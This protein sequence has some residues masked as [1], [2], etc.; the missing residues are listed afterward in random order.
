MAGTVT[1]TMSNPFAQGGDNK[2]VADWTATAGGAV[3]VALCSTFAA[4]Q[5]ST[6]KYASPQPSK[7]RGKLVKAETAPGASG[8]LATTLPT[9][10]YDIT[11]L[12]AYS[13]DIASGYLEDRSGTVAEQW[14]P[15]QPVSVDDDI[16]LTIANAGASTK[17]R[18]ILHF[19]GE[20]NG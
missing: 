8:D 6:Y 5:L 16:T 10:A 7:F 18:I 9:A 13:Q 15:I 19:E 20:K 2:V 14:V 4:A 17:G 11:L 3:S 1:L 12:D